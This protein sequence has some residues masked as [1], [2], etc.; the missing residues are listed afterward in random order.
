MKEY[1]WFLGPLGELSYRDLWALST[2]NNKAAVNSFKMSM[3]LDPWTASV[4]DVRA[5]ICLDLLQQ[6]QPQAPVHW[7]LCRLLCT[8]GMDP[9]QPRRLSH[10]YLKQSDTLLLW[11]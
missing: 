4:V 9:P 2:S 3:Y 7:K 5:Y 10:L 11:G 1:D 8:L 6:P